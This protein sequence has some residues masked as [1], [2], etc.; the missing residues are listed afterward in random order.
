MT[1]P[2]TYRVFGLVIRSDFEFEVLEEVT[3]S[4]AE[5]DLV[6]KRSSGI[7]RPEPPAFDP[8][9]D[10]Q[11]DQQY[12][13]WVVTGAFLVPDDHTVLVETHA[14][15]SDHQVSQAFLGLVMSVV[16]ERRQLLCL[17]AS[18]VNLGGRA[19][20]F[21][22][23]KGAGKSTTS[24]ALLSRGHLP[25]TDDLVAVEPQG[26]DLAIRPGFSS[27]KLWPDT[28]DALA[29]APQESDRLIH[30]RI[31]K[32]QKRMPTAIPDRNIVMGA[33][34]VLSRAA[35]VTDV[36]ALRLPAH[37]ALQKIL[38]YTFMARYGE[39]RLGPAHLQNHMRRCAAVVAQIP[40]YTLMIP[41]DLAQLNRL[42]AE[43]ERYVGLAAPKAGHGPA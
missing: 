18:A 37:E 24:A 32:M 29:L 13:H 15:V 40:V 39:T 3:A 25:V 27:M 5:I 41:E 16:L 21:L 34:F 9:F 22:G 17:H 43:I 23:D 42:S 2:R 19:A 14:G 11:P 35:E 4:E 36:T 6:V 30:P 7:I 33:A 10:I 8:L 26:A 1:T 38:R 20:L 31:T 28:I 12:M